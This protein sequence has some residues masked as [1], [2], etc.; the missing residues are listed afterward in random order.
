MPPEVSIIARSTDALQAM[1]P[2][3]QRHN[4]ARASRQD[5]MNALKA[6]MEARYAALVPQ[7]DFIKV[8]RQELPD[9]GFYVDELTQIGYV[10][11]F[12]MPFYLPRTCVSTGYQGTFG[13]GFATALGVKVANPHKPVLAVSGDGGFLF[14]AQELATAVQQQI[15]TVTLIFNDGA[16]GNVHR[17]QKERYENR[18]IAS[19]LHN[20][21][22]V[23]YAEAFGAQGLRAHTPEDVRHAIQQGFDT[24]GPTLV[25][26]PVEEMPSPWSLL[27]SPRVRP[28]P[29]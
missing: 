9:D 11:R 7:M 22:I 12:A 18:V 14:T 24:P 16:Y 19:E 28:R 13:W 23:K 5:E 20:P 25:D 29:Q 3:V 21:D 6:T 26:I 15:S 4:T 10:S 27:F 2:A 1:I 17:M 8:I